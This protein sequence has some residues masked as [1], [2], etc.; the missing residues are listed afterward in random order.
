MD[1][2]DVIAYSRSTVELASILLPGQRIEPALF[3]LFSVVGIRHIGVPRQNIRLD[4]RQA[5]QS[6]V[7]E[8]QVI[9]NNLLGRQAEPLRDRNVVIGRCLEDLCFHK[10]ESVMETV[11]GNSMPAKESNVPR[12]TKSVSP[13]FSR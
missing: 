1:G 6:V 9:F 12:Y 4:L 11:E 8:S 3:C 5:I 7:T 13:V 10:H 2:F